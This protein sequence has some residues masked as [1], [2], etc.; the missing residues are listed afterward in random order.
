[1]KEPK[2]I[3][4]NFTKKKRIYKIQLKIKQHIIKIEKE[5]NLNKSYKLIPTFKKV[6]QKTII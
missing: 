1:M 2:V 4:N 6:S 3:I 5:T